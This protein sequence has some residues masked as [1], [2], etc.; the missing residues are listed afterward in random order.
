MTSRS[1]LFR[2]YGAVLQAILRKTGQPPSNK[3]RVHEMLKRAF[4][5]TSLSNISDRDLWEFLYK[6]EIHF[7]VEYGIELLPEKKSL[8]EL[9]EEIS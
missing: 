4:D 9:L 7:L 3:D 6:I 5:I 8:K 2:R 1:K